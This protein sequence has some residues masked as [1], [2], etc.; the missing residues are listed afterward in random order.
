MGAIRRVRAGCGK[1]LV[2]GPMTKSKLEQA[3]ESRVRN[4]N[5]A[6]RE[7]A[8]SQFSA[9]KKNRARLADIESQLDV[10]DARAPS[11]VEEVRF[12][13]SQRSALAYEKAHLLTANSRI[14]AELFRFMEE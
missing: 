10:L 4:L 5:D 9:Y 12:R 6:Q 11:S 2:R 13:Q 14:A 8:L 7:L 3:V 1:F